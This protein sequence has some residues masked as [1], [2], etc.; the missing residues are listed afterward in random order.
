MTNNLKPLIKITV[1]LYHI[2][3]CDD[4]EGANPLMRGD[5]SYLSG[6]CSGLSGDCS[7]L[8]GNCSNLKGNCTGLIGSCTNLIG[9]LDLITKEQRQKNP[10]IQFY[11]K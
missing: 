4:V 9:N 7:Y 6:N 3:N 5:C 8:Y 1:I 11:C 10:D 2:L